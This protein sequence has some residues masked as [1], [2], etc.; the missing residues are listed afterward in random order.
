VDFQAQRQSS[1]FKNDSP[2]GYGTSRNSERNELC[3]KTSKEVKQA[4]LLDV[5]L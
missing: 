5:F 2:S 4:F 3:K 1:A